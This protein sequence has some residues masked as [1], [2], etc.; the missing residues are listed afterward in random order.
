[1]TYQVSGGLPECVQFETRIKR[2]N[3]TALLLAMPGGAEGVLQ[4]GT[5]CSRAGR[6]HAGKAKEGEVL[7]GAQQAGR[8]R[9]GVAHGGGCEERQGW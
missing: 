5:T 1:M 3:R 8:K 4:G 2:P 9:K 7:K 6:R